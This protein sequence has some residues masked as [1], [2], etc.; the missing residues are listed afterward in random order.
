ML[1]PNIRYRSLVKEVE[2]IA[3]VQQKYFLE[4]GKFTGNVDKLDIT[5]PSLQEKN[6]NAQS[7]WNPHIK[8][9]FGQTKTQNT[10]IKTAIGFI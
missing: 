3:Y 6:T 7:M 9:I 1:L 5:R 2:R 10:P 4:K 8:V